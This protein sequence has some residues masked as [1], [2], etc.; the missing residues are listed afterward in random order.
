MLSWNTS[1]VRA[2]EFSCQDRTLCWN[3]FHVRLEHFVRTYCMLDRNSSHVGMEHFACRVR[4]LCQHTFHVRSEH[5]H[6]S[7]HAVPKV[8]MEEDIHVAGPSHVMQ[9]EVGSGEAGVSGLVKKLEDEQPSLVMP[10][11][12]PSPATQTKVDEVEM[13]ESSAMAIDRPE[14]GV[15]NLK[16]RI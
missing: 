4:T 8:A 11:I 3:T 14:E 16:T 13:G 7:G 10:F 6:M 1:H 15:Q 9:A 5:F 12:I 2:K